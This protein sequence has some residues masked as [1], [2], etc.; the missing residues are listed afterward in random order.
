MT[1]KTIEVAL[2]TLDKQMQP[3]TEINSDL[4][5]AY[6]EDMAAGAAFPAVQLVLDGETFYCV[7]GWH[8]VLAARRK[9]IEEIEAAVVRGTRRDAVLAAAGA[10]ATHGLRRTN[11]DKRRSVMTLLGDAEWAKWSDREI[12]RRCAV[13]GKT[14]SELRNKLTAEV[15]QSDRTYT[16][17]HGTTATM[18]TANIGARPVGMPEARASNSPPEAHQ[19]APRPTFNRTNDNIEWAGWSWNPVTGCKHGCPYCYA[20]DMANRFSGGD[21][22]PKFHE[23]RLPAPENTR[24][25]MTTP[26]GDKVFVCSMSDLFGP[27]VPDEWI[28]KVLDQARN[29][30]QW[31][32]LFLTKS[33][34]R[35]PDLDFPQNAWVGTTVDTQARVKAAEKAMKKVHVRKFV[36][37]EPLLEPVV[38]GNIKVFDWVIIGGQSRTSTS[39]EFQ[40]QWS[41]VEYIVRQAREHRLPVYFKTNLTVR[42]REFP[43]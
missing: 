7:D 34:E 30:P 2:I 20:R 24:P 11:E 12:A 5:R 38:F 40:P 31:T 4:V 16:T 15:P 6:A 18:K 41:W 17:K 32:F 42:P 43:E 22:S 35:L 3:R 28:E 23:E 21:F 36:S 10:N 29:N 8:R 26:G 25:D 27:W 37:C 13:D 33:P 39:P 1:N 14:V 9:E 19:E